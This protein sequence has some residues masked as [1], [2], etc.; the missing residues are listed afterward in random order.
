MGTNAVRHRQIFREFLQEWKQD[1]WQP[2]DDSRRPGYM[3]P[4][5]DRGWQYRMNHSPKYQPSQMKDVGEIR[6]LQKEGESPERMIAAE[7]L[8]IR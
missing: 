4:L 5:D 6:P 7:S 1:V 8:P 3:R 2:Q